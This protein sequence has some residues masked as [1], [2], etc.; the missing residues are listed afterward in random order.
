MKQQG[1]GQRSF[2]WDDPA[3]LIGIIL[4]LYLGA[5]AHGLSPMTRLR[6]S[7]STSVTWSSGC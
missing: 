4:V 6:L 5:G 3:V 1:G 2:T 7:M